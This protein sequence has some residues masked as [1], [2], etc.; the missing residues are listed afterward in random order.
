VAVATERLLISSEVCE[1]CGDCGV[2]SNCIAIEPLDTELG[3]KRKINQSVCN[4]DYSCLKGFCPSFVTVTG[5]SP[6]A[7]AGSLG[8]D[9][10]PAG[11]LPL[12]TIPEVG[13]G[14]SLL[15]TGIGGAGVVTIGAILGM[16]AHIEGKGGTILDMS[17]F[18]QRNGSVMSHVRFTATPGDG[19]HTARIPAGGAD[20]VIGCDPIVAASADCLAMM[21]PDDGRVILNSFVAPTN[22]FALDPDYRVDLTMLRRRIARRVG[23]DHVLPVDATGTATA[24]LGD[25]IGANMMLV[26]FAWQRGLVPLRLQSIHAALELNGT[27]LKMNLRAFALGRLMAVDPARVAAMIG[28]D[29][30]PKG[31]PETLDAL[32]AS[33]VRHLT[34]YQ[35]DRLAARY[36]ALVDRVAAAEAGPGAGSGELAM[37]VARTYAK[38]LAYKDE[39]EVARLLTGEGLRRELA[40]T[41]DGD[42]KIALNLAP[43]FLSRRD[44]VTGR[45]RKRSFGPWM[46][47]PM[48]LLARMKR[49]R[50]GPL[51]VFGRHPHRR[52]ERALIGEYEALVDEI[53]AGLTPANHAAAVALASVHHGIRGYDVVKEA[54][55]RA[56][57]GRL[58]AARA[59]FQDSG[60]VR[61]ATVPA[62]V[63]G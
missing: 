14:R 28:G 39:Y 44:P 15:V 5:G 2:Q 7:R 37:A 52:T 24:L 51:D 26:G 3:R 20:V 18:A 60:R 1:G 54:S 50:G 33:R 35:D 63:A 11:G 21:K 22:A 40:D 23:E 19:S 32:V 34:A 49:L 47:G 61:V 10:D 43:P 45:L 55:I 58:A 59:A 9:A 31:E 12:P 30:A 6:R 62:M 56:A 46:L 38:L 53:L 41:F 42:V 17:G 57:H 16:A 29:V 13:E 8:G 4:Q 36:R 25:A 27:A 48:R